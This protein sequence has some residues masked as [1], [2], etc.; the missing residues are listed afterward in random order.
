MRWLS[1][2]QV[3]RYETC[4]WQWYGD[5]I[6][7]FDQ[8]PNEPFAF[9]RSVHAAMASYWLGNKEWPEVL[10]SNIEWEYENIDVL[11]P[12]F[13]KEVTK[14]N[15][16]SHRENEGI[17]LIRKL[18]TKIRKEFPNVK[19]ITT[20]QKYKK[21]GFVGYVD[22]RGTLSGVEHILD[23]KTSNKPYKP[24]R[25]HEDD[26]LTCYAALT[27][28]R[29]VGYGTM[30]RSDGSTQLLL[31]SRTKDE[32]SAY[33]DKVDKIQTEMDSGVY[34]PCE[35]WYCN[36]CSYQEQCPAKGDF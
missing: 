1:H 7:R 18:T 8:P 4:P 35:G 27:G 13:G 14:A 28:V 16:L 33:W 17:N 31:S 19:C 22:W 5:K 36:W 3:N 29:N 12:A 20:E 26:Q 21:V 10:K 9:G 32:I 30:C 15:I 6:L 11:E 23:W 24:E 34:K 25:V 2:S